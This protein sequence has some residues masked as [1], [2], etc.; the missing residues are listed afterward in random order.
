MPH[1]YIDS[2]DERNDEGGESE[3]SWDFLDETHKMCFVVNNEETIDIIHQFRLEV[4]TIV[5]TVIWTSGITLKVSMN[6]KEKFV[7][8]KLRNWRTI[9]HISIETFKLTTRNEIKT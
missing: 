1:H 7:N 3:S 6:V 2:E 8:F 5:F 4:K 9:P